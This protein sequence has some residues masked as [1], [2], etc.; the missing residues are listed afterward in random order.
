MHYPFMHK[1][2]ESHQFLQFFLAQNRFGSGQFIVPAMVEIE[3]S[4]TLQV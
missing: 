1:P 4:P 3:V 2:D